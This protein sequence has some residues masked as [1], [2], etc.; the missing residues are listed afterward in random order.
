MILFRVCSRADNLSMDESPRILPWKNFARI[1]V[2]QDF[3]DDTKCLDS[4]F[5]ENPYEKTGRCDGTHPRRLKESQH[6]FMGRIH[7]NSKL[8]FVRQ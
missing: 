1:H 4:A 2:S 6:R 3:A 5:V 8:D 7:V